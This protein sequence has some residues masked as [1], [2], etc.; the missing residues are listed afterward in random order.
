MSSHGS[1][2]IVSVIG[3]KNT[4]KTTLIEK[5]V[6]TFKKDGYRVGVMKYALREFQM[7]HEGKDTY[8]F[9]RSGAYV[10]AIT[11]HDKMAVI[12]RV[13]SPPPLDKVIEAHFLDTDIVILEGYRGRDCPRICLVLPGKEPVESESAPDNKDCPVLRL[14]VSDQNCSP[15]SPE[16]LEEAVGFVRGIIESYR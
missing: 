9:Y 8:R 10:V 1:L 3:G 12:K 5:L 13:E 15:I 16:V 6:S 2:P 7:D 4:G 14:N 11:S